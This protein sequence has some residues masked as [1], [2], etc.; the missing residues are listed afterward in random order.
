MKRIVEPGTIPTKDLHQYII[1]S[2]APRPIAFVSTLDENGVEN[3]APY[4]F[5]NLPIRI[6]LR[7]ATPG[8]E[9]L[10]GVHAN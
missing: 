8:T 9:L 4:S 3:L 6:E 5:F 1:G 7:K 2:I 10:T